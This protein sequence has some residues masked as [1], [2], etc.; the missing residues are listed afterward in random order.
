[1]KKDLDHKILIVDGDKESIARYSEIF[2]DKYRV[3][4]SSSCV[5]AINIIKSTEAVNLVI[6][7]HKLPDLSGIEFLKEIKR[8]RSSVPVIMVTGHGDEDVAVKYF[9]NGIRDY[10]KKPF[11]CKELIG[12]VEFCLS[13]E[14]IGRERN[15]VCTLSEHK[16]EIGFHRSAV[17]P[18]NNYKIQRA[19]EFIDDNYTAK[20]NLEMVA[21]KAC[22]SKYHFSRTFKKATGMTYQNYL[23]NRR[24][25]KAKEIL[26]NGDFTITEI[27]FSVGYADVTHFGR[28]FKN[29][30]GVTPSGYKTLPRRKARS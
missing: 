10:L 27:A 14:K 20:I 7:E 2:R 9:R 11:S 18:H 23:N 3:R 4:V 8:R 22:M 26:E 30:V 5:G 24:V 1:M 25:E 28:I 16:P 29:V 6:L 12:K 21:G 15:E 19:L 17:S 13:L